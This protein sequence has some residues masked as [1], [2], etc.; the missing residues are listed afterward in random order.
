MKLKNCV[1]DDKPLDGVRARCASCV[2]SGERRAASGAGLE[3]VNRGSATG[4]RPTPADVT[5]R[6]FRPEPLRPRRAHPAPT[7]PDPCTDLIP[8]KPLRLCIANYIV[9]M[10]RNDKQLLF[11]IFPSHLC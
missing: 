5:L 7:P 1:K 10:H 2:A 8:S 9:T 6:E 11:L 3:I 4:A